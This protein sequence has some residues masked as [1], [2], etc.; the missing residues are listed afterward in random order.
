MTTLREAIALIDKNDHRAQSWAEIDEFSRELGLSVY[1]WYPA[2]EDRMK[3]YWVHS[4]NCT[5]TWVGTAA[6]FLDGE[7]VAVSTQKGRKWDEEFEWVSR[8]AAA[9]VREFILSLE[10]DE[11]RSYTIVNLDQDF[12]LTEEDAK[13][14]TYT[15]YGKEKA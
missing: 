14:A 12:T 13:F 1:G 4:W 15:V 11:Q 5:D 3:K 7:L 9:K 2:F 10:E 8:E 6:Y